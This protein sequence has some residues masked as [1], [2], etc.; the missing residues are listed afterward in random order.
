MTGIIILAT[1]FYI[2]PHMLVSDPD[3]LLHS[4]TKQLLGA[5]TYLTATEPTDAQYSINLMYK[6]T[7]RLVASL[8]AILS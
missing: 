1:T 3:K 5:C 7:C 8:K 6:T 2:W 4:N